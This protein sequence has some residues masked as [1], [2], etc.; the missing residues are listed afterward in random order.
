MAQAAKHGATRSRARP[1]AS[2][3]QR[4]GSQIAAGTA[5]SK[6]AEGGEP[7]VPDGHDLAEVV[8]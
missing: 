1:M 6:P 2:S 8:A 3:G 7:A 4:A 5:N